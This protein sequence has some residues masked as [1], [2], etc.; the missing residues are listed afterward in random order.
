MPYG[1]V[2][3]FGPSYVLSGA[4]IVEAVVALGDLATI[5]PWAYIWYG[6]DGPA[7]PR[8]GLSDRTKGASVDVEDL[9]GRALDA[10]AADELLE[11]TGPM[12]PSCR[13]VKELRL[14]LV[15]L[16]GRGGGVRRP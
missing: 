5:A 3:P 6:C 1:C 8:Y 7:G 12:A 11:A 13:R 16:E 9:A 2:G 14:G 10:D 15:V 4:R